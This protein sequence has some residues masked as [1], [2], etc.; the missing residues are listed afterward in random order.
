MRIEILFSKNES[1]DYQIL[2]DICKESSDFKPSDKNHAFN[3]VKFD[4]SGIELVRNIW[5][6]I[7]EW[8]SSFLLVNDF[9]ST[10]EELNAKIK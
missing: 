4:A 3:S 1:E 10:I 2:L 6:I 9:I 5:G 8:E 7:Q